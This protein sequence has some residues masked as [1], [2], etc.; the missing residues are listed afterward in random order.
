VVIASWLFLTARDWPIMKCFMR[1]AN[2]SKAFSYGR[3]PLK[4]YVESPS[5]PLCAVRPRRDGWFLGSQ[6]I[7][8]KAG[9]PFLRVSAR[10]NTAVFPHVMC[11]G[12][13]I[14]EIE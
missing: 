6:T 10:H 7:I 9:A 1:G 8:S 4:L 11:M 12:D 5:F 13:R 14:L 2:H 3:A